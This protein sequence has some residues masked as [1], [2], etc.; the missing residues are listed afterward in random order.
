MSLLLLAGLL[1]D[2]MPWLA[3]VLVESYRELKTAGPEE[4]REISRRLM[5]LVKHTVRGPFGERMLGRSKSGH[6]LLMELPHLIDRAVS[7]SL[8]TR[9]ASE[10]QELVGP[11]EKV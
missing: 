6:F 3:E 11:E 5:R 8:D 10:D 1:R 2:R 7:S 9:L 4:A